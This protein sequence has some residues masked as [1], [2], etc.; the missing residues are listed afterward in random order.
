MVTRTSAALVALSLICVL[1]G[2]TKVAPVPPGTLEIHFSGIWGTAPNMISQREPYPFLVR[3]SGF[4][5]SRAF[6]LVVS[7]EQGHMVASSVI[8]YRDPMQINPV[9]NYQFH[10]T[11]NRESCNT[12]EDRAISRESPESSKL[13]VQDLYDSDR[14]DYRVKLTAEVVTQ[15]KKVLAKKSYVTLIHCASQTI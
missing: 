3:L 1:I 13:H 10:Q 2:C 8:K 14:E 6:M 15:D 7:N 9:R 12:L 5:P 11:V 4:V